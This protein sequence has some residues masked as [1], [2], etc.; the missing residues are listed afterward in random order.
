MS[1]FSITPSPESIELERQRIEAELAAAGVLDWKL[2]EEPHPL[3]DNVIAFPERN[4]ER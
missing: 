4:R 2:G 3:P 1:R